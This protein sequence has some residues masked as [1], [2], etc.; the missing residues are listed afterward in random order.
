MKNKLILLLLSVMILP[1]M[2]L[3]VFADETLKST[4]AMYDNANLFSDTE[5]TEIMDYI[6]SLYFDDIGMD[7]VVLTSED[8]DNDI[9]TYTD[10]FY[11]YNGFK[12]DGIL[13]FINNDDV[14]INTSG[15]SIIAIN[16]YEI[17]TILDA[18]WNEFLEYDFVNCTKK[19]ANKASYYVEIAY[20]NGYSDSNID[21]N[22]TFPEPSIGE[23][24]K[25]AF[26]PSLTSIF[27]S[28]ITAIVIGVC[29][30]IKHNHTSPKPNNDKYMNNTF[31]ITNTNTRYITTQHKVHHDYYRPKSSSSGG[32]HSSGSSHRS[33]SGRSHGGGGRSR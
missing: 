21:T 12:K 9:T 6:K 3:P 33:S 25:T 26:W 19:M 24:L 22:I 32:G 14:Y 10:D 20:E 8:Y 18:G 5:E 16:D 30:V 1:Y 29:C 17:E 13:F 15:F 31:S 7:V 23:K 2:I 11:D 27:F 4:F 28:I